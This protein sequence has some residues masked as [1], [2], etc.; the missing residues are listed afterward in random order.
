[1]KIKAGECASFEPESL[2][3]NFGAA[4]FSRGYLIDAGDPLS[5]LRSDWSSKG[6]FKIAYYCDLQIDAMINKAAAT[7]DADARHQVEAQIAEQL[8]ADQ[9][10]CPDA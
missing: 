1:V 2:A 6:S 3:G 4:L 10:G 8:Q 9:A 5:Y 7:E